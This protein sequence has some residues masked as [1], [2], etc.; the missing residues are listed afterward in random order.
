MKIF[1]MGDPHGNFSRLLPLVYRHEP[2]AVILLGDLEVRTPLERVLADVLK[3]TEV[4]WIPGNHDTDTRLTTECLFQSALA[5]RNLHGRVVEIAGVKVGGL[6]GVFRDEIW[7]PEFGDPKLK[8]Y[9]EFEIEIKTKLAYGELTLPVADGLLRKHLSTIFWDD[10]YGLYG[11]S[12]DVLVTH[13]APSC[14][15][16]GVRVLDDLAESMGVTKIFHGHHHGHYI[17]EIA[18]GICVIGTDRAQ[19]VDSEGKIVTGAR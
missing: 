18:G 13:E 3:L 2:D 5:D 8:N 7:S 1:Y 16:H 19:I 4:W 12:A 11:Q 6:G 9:R 14:H 10:W 17:D 15:R